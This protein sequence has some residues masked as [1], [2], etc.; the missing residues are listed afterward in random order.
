MFRIVF[1]AIAL[2]GAFKIGENKARLEQLDFYLTKI[3][4][5]SSGLHLIEYAYID[6]SAGLV[7]TQDMNQA[8][9]LNYWDAMSLKS[10]M[11]KFAPAAQ[12]QLET[13]S[14]LITVQPI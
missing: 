12:I 5:Q 10:L 9:V 4:G 7:F 11:K 6:Q 8:T 14:S 3:E 1:S 2:Y 13:V